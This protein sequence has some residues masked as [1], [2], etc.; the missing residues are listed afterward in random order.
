MIT[1]KAFTNDLIG[2]WNNEDHSL[3]A[4]FISSFVLPICV[5]TTDTK[6]IRLISLIIVSNFVLLYKSLEVFKGLLPNSF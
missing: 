1:G 4:A 6:S 5:S 3:V 2:I